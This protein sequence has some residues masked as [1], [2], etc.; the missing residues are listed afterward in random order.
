MTYSE[1]PSLQVEDS[2][3]YFDWYRS[4]YSE[5]SFNDVKT[6]LRKLD[7]TNPVQRR[8]DLS[9]IFDCLL[10]IQE[11]LGSFNIVELG[12]HD[13]SLAD[14][15]ALTSFGWH[16][17]DL[18]NVVHRVK[19]RNKHFRFTELD[20][21]IWNLPDEEFRNTQVFMASHALEHLSDD[22][23]PLLIEWMRHFKYI[24]LIVP[25][26]A[27]GQDWRGYDGMHLL[28]MGYRR[29]GMELNK[30]WTPLTHQV[31]WDGSW[32]YLGIKKE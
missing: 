1:A 13:G 4:H 12:C 27:N 17:Y 3:I 15:F 8:Y 9:F 10:K 22:E 6:I 19:Q 28:K 25:L 30:I 20:T 16:G 31:G 11:K 2:P 7:E 14:Q 24:V 21:Q 5:L 26:L 18:L 32:D 23:L 29:L